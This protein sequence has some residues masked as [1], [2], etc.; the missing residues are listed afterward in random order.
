MT[1]IRSALGPHWDLYY[2]YVCFH[3]LLSLG[4]SIT[5]LLN[6]GVVFGGPAVFTA[7]LSFLLDCYASLTA[8]HKLI[9]IYSRDD[10]ETLRR[11][12][13]IRQSFITTLEGEAALKTISQLS[14]QIS[15]SY[16]QRIPLDVVVSFRYLEDYL[17]TVPIE[18]FLKS[19]ALSTFPAT[20]VISRDFNSFITKGFS[21]LFILIPSCILPAIQALTAASDIYFSSLGSWS[22]HHSSIVDG[23][24][25]PSS[26]LVSESFLE[27]SILIEP[28]AKLPGLISLSILY[29][30]LM[31]TSYHSEYKTSYEI[32][33]G[34]NPSLLLTLINIFSESIKWKLRLETIQRYVQEISLSLQESAPLLPISI[35]TALTLFPSAEFIL[36]TPPAR[37]PTFY[38]FVGSAWIFRRSFW[39]TY[40]KGWIDKD[41]VDETTY[42]RVGLRYPEG[43]ERLDRREKRKEIKVKTRRKKEISLEELN[44]LL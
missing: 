23:V 29:S 10:R 7:D 27:S 28:F 18:M 16:Q 33:F 26:Q 19:Q 4:E 44:E 3:L 35:Y 12:L 11:Y 36:P 42:K 20:L 13:I 24:L 32:D 43:Y 14:S 5:L 40:Q 31:L 39:H 25:R 34:V 1:A 38:D 21:S 37:Y 17:L 22:L 30:I 9:S 8:F 6:T 2:D 41:N 15:K